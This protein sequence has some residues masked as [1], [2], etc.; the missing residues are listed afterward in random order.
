MEQLD[1]IKK[2]TELRIIKGR[3]FVISF[4]LINLIL[5]I[6][7]FVF[8]IYSIYVAIASVALSILLFFISFTK[9]IWI[10]NSLYRSYFYLALLFSM[11]DQGFDGVLGSI[12]V[13]VIIFDIYSSISLLFSKSVEE[14]LYM[15]KTRE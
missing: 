15:R 13:F 11:I 10:I 9:F 5:T 8:K 1:K 14:Y 12:C 4:S 7:S 3:R 6:I 2:E